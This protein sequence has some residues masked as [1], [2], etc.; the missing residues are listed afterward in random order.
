MSVAAARSVSKSRQTALGRGVFY[1]SRLAPASLQA[2][3]S[4]VHNGCSPAWAA[5]A[6]WTQHDQESKNAAHTRPLAVNGQ[7]KWRRHACA[8]SAPTGA[9][10]RRAEHLQSSIGGSGW[11]DLEHHGGNNARAHRTRASGACPSQKDFSG[12]VYALREQGLTTTA[13]QKIPFHHTADFQGARIETH[14][15]RDTHH[16]LIASHCQLQRNGV[17]DFCD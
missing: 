10:R 3:L 17:T 1:A 11:Q 7:D 14:D 9:D 6:A 2:A 13:W 4:K 15:E 5:R 8:D 12:G 16:R